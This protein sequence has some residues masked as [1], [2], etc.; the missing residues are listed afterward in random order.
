MRQWHFALAP[1]LVGL[2]LLCPFLCGPGELLCAS[3]CEQGHERVPCNKGG[4]SCICQG[5]TLATWLNAGL[6]VTVN[7]WNVSLSLPAEAP[8]APAPPERFGPS[9]LRMACATP[10][11]ATVRVLIQSLLS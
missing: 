3:Q 6:R 7:N 4:D 2:L 8:K 11:G 10:D 5:A 9:S 1:A